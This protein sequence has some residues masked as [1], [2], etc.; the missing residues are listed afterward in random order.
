MVQLDHDE[1]MGPL[2]GSMEPEFEVQRTVKRAELAAFLCLLKKVTGPIKVHVD[3]TELL[4]AKSGR[5][6]FT[7]QN[8]GRTALSGRKEHFGGSGTCKGASHEERKIHVAF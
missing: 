7:D 8:L 4:Q 3:N 2:Y 5:C 1:E 6:R